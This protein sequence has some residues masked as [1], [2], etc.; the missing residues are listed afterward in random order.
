MKL[1]L[2]FLNRLELKLFGKYSH[3]HSPVSTFVA[4]ATAISSFAVIF[5]TGVIMDFIASAEQSTRDTVAYIFIGASFVATALRCIR[6]FKALTTAGSRA[7]F[8]AYVLC[9]FV[10]ASFIFGFIAFWVAI[11][12]LMLLVLWIFYY[13]FLG[14]A[15]RPVKTHAHYSDG[16]KEE[17]EYTGKGIT[18]EMYYK[19]KESGN[20]FVEQ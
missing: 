1:S 17:V 6:P 13:F 11:A 8:I 14:G 4:A 2:N 12:L 18:G 9:L 5:I 10:A 15:E 7:G 20:E 3:S 19:G 16:T